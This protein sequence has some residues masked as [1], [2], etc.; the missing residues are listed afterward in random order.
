M[1]LG[2]RIRRQTKTSVAG[3]LFVPQ[4]HGPEQKDGYL[5]R[6]SVPLMI[7]AWPGNEQM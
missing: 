6:L 4:G 2:T 7:E 5:A 1:I 3:G